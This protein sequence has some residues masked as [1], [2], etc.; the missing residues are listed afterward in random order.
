MYLY[1][2]DPTL[3]PA[4]AGLS[5]DCGCGG[6]GRLGCCGPA[7][8]AGLGNA[9]G[10]LLENARQKLPGERTRLAAAHRNLQQTVGRI[11]DAADAVRAEVQAAQANYSAF[12]SSALNAL[13]SDLQS[14]QARAVE[15][16]AEAQPVVGLT[17]E[18]VLANYADRNVGRLWD[19]SNPGAKGI[20]THHIWK[21][22][23]LAADTITGLAA[24]A[25]AIL[26]DVRAEQARAAEVI[27][28]EIGQA[29]VDERV[30]AQDSIAD[31]IELARLQRLEEFEQRKYEY[32]LAALQRAEELA[33][34]RE[35]WEFEQLQWQRDREQQRF[36]A[37]QQRLAA[38][39][40]A[41]QQRL[42]AE[43]ALEQQQLQAELSQQ[44][45]ASAGGGASWGGYGV[46][47]VDPYY[48]GSTGYG[49]Q[50][51]QQPVYGQPS[52]QQPVTPQVYQPQSYQVPT[53][54]PTTLPYGQPQAPASGWTPGPNEMFGLGAVSV[55]DATEEAL[56][57]ADRQAANP[58][59][60]R[61]WKQFGQPDVIPTGAGVRPVQVVMEDSDGGGVLDVLKAGGSILSA[62]ANS[63]AASEAVRQ[64]GPNQ[65]PPPPPPSYGMG[66]GGSALGTVALG[67]GLVGVGYLLFGRK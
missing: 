41:E 5:G 29:Q 52:Y 35:Q 48:G 51:F 34:Q 50:A 30:G 21:V 22:T 65:T 43:L 10:G 36:D 8:V 42:Q 32:E 66:G 26:D 57:T 31:Q 6:G 24:E 60:G 3:S 64:F 67:A 13:V 17:Q 11:D 49:A 9:Y 1:L 44:Y 46:P 47:L 4:L 38:Q 7:G 20:D 58:N 18:W 54:Q 25:Q 15:L 55:D 63:G 12:Y 14:Q 61:F 28:A 27:E 2:D 59:R 23:E 45:G 56:A 16:L 62:L 33:A 39:L 40:A 37:E 53:P 19:P